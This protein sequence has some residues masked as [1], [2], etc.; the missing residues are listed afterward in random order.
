MKDQRKLVLEW[1]I[2]ELMILI[3]NMIILDKKSG[4][5]GGVEVEYKSNLRKDKRTRQILD[6][7]LASG[8]AA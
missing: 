7:S 4:A 8:R 5:G 6:I 3:E 2:L 1:D